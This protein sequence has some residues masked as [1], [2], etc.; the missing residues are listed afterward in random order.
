MSVPSPK[1]KTTPWIIVSIIAIFLLVLVGVVF[2]KQA[3]ESTPYVY[4]KANPLPLPEVQSVEEATPVVVETLDRFDYAS[5]ML[6]LANNGLYRLLSTTTRESVATSTG[7]TT[8]IVVPSVAAETLYSTH[9]S[10]WPAE[11]TYPELGAI[12]PFKRIIAYYG[13][14]YSTQMGALG[15]YEKEDMKR[16]LLT[17]VA[18]WEK[19]DPSTPVIPAIDYIAV[20]AQAEAGRDG[21]Y[22]AQMPDSEIQKAVDIANELE[23]IVLLEVQVGL[24]DLQRE[25]EALETWLKLPNVHLAIDPEF[26]MKNGQKPGTVIGTVDAVDVNVAIAYLDSLVAKHSLPPKIVIVH[27]FTQNMVTNATLIKPTPTVQVVMVMD[28]WGPGANKFGTYNLVITPQPV[29]FAGFKVFYKNDLKTPSTGLLTPEEIL[30][31]SPKPIFIQY[32]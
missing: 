11:T 31:L 8:M 23:G 32:Q 28:G 26:R 14:F 1:E 15:E 7:S 9:N 22:R 3:S 27:R 12:L 4:I 13:N 24:S 6:R 21:L 17:E 16:R 30:T 20:V 19:A 10:T 25:I 5:R 18:N 2:A 29:Q